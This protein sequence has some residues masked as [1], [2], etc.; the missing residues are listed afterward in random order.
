MKKIVLIIVGVLVAAGAGLFLKKQKEHVAALPAAKEYSKSVETTVAK[1]KSVSRKREFLAEVFSLK[2]AG[3][4]SKFTANIKKIYV[5]ENDKVKKGELLVTLD[6]KDILAN[7][8]SLK[9]QKKALLL[10]LKNARDILQ[11][12]KKLY[13]IE[14]V[15][16]EILDASNAK[17]QTT[18]SAVK[19]AEAK[20]TQTKVQLNYLNLVAP[21]DGVI[22]S[23]LLD[24][25]SIAPAGKPV[26]T[27]NT[28]K[29]KLTFSFSQNQ[30]PIA[31]GQKVYLQKRLIGRVSKIYDD[32]KN[33]LL[34]AEVTLQKRIDFANKSFVHIKVEIANAK[35]CSVPLN[36]LL[37]TQEGVYVMQ[38]Q[39]G[40]FSKLAVDLLLEDNSAAV[41]SPCPKYR[42]ALGSEAK[43][44]M[45]PAYGKIIIDKAQ[46]NEK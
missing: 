25:G 24:E 5:H 21:F 34:V 10:D 26:V 27:L 38:Y 7:L 40:K 18:R 16:K 14:A 15:S 3:I 30:V 33:A 8:T 9:A 11:R 6:D 1:E 29:Q 41:V 4:A 36:A 37:H 13:A 2:Q 12:N 32:A 19:S 39:E 46:T 23:K 31:E 17:Y 22:G 28:Q 45:L 43:L 20:I 35:G 42:V 44:S